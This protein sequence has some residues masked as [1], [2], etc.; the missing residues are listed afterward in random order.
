VLRGFRA[1]RP[2]TDLTSRRGQRTWELLGAAAFGFVLRWN[3]YFVNRYRTDQIALSNLASLVGVIGGAAV[4]ALF[5]AGT[6]LFGAYGIG[7]A[8]G[9][10]SCQGD[11]DLVVATVLYRPPDT[12]A[13]TGVAGRG[14][15]TPI[16]VSPLGIRVPSRC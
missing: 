2:A 4:L 10:A 16:P 11:L 13:G 3:V 1:G 5:P 6:R 15:V 9:F 8:L 7:L 12:G 14:A